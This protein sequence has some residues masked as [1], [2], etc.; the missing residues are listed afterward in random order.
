M[1]SK[2]SFHGDRK[3]HST[4]RIRRQEPLANSN[5]QDAA[6]NPK[7]LMNC[8]W[9][10]DSCFSVTLGSFETPPLTQADAKE[11]LDLV[12]CYLAEFPRSKS[13]IQDFGHPNVYGM[14]LLRS[15][16]RSGIDC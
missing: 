12:R 1:W 10:H 4:A 6:K 14:C 15:N 11:N 8:A 3:L 9:F 16:W 7:F 2:H 13:N 5:I